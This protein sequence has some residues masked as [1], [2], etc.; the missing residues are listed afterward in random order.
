[1]KAWKAIL[2][3]LVIA[4]GIPAL[5][6]A[7][8]TDRARGV[9]DDLL[10][11]V[12]RLN[13]TVRGHVVQHREATLVLRSDDERTYTINTAALGFAA[14]HALRDGR[15]VTV[16]LK[17]SLPGAMPIAVALEPADGSVKRFQRVEGSVEAVDDERIT[18]RARDGRRLSLERARIVG[19]APHVWPSETATLIYQDEPRVAGVWIESRDV[20]PAALPRSVR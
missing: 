19:D 20:E 13:R 14:L 8:G 18:F 4:S 10:K 1:M 5:A 12:L 3:I 2:A 17:D 6:C 7:Q 15:S 16:S 9:F 11:D